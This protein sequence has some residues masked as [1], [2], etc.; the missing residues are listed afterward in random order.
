MA[1]LTDLATKRIKDLASQDTL[2]GFFPIDS[3]AFGTKKFDASKL[4]TKLMVETG[5]NSLDTALATEIAK[6]TALGMAVAD[7][8][9]KVKA[10][11]HFEGSKSVS[12]IS[13]MDVTSID[14]GTMYSCTDAGNIRYYSSS[15]G[16]ITTLKVRKF[17]EVAW[18]GTDWYIVGQDRDTD[19]S[20]YTKTA[21]LAPLAISGDWSDIANKP[22][23]A[24]VATSGSYRDLSDTPNGV[25]TISMNGTALATFSAGS[26]SNMTA[27]ITVPDFSDKED[28]SNKVNSIAAVASAS[29]KNYPSEK[30]VAIALS[31][32]QDTINNLNEIIAGATAGSTAAQPDDLADVAFSGDYNDLINTPSG[33]AEGTWHGNSEAVGSGNVVTDIDIDE[34]GVPQKTYGTAI[35]GI[36]VTDEEGHEE[37]APVDENGNVTLGGRFV[38]KNKIIEFSEEVE[39]VVETV[40]DLKQDIDTQLVTNF[41][42]ANITK[43]SDYG[44]LIGSKVDA[45]DGATAY[46]AFTLPINSNIRIIDPESDDT[47]T[48]L[49]VYATQSYSEPMMFGIFEYDYGT[50]Q[51]EYVADTGKVNITSGGRFDFPLKHKNPDIDQLSSGKLYYIAIHLRPGRGTGGPYLMSNDGINSTDATAINLNPQLMCWTKD[52]RNNPVIDFTQ[53]DVGF[54]VQ[55]PNGNYVYG[56]WYDGGYTHQFYQ[57]PAFF[58]QLR[59]SDPTPH[60]V[61]PSNPPFVDLSGETITFASATPSAVFNTADVKLILR[62][63]NP[64][65]NVTITEWTVYDNEQTDAAGYGKRIYNSGFTALTDENTSGITLTELGE[66]GSGTDIYGHKYTYAAGVQLT[67]NE[68]YYF[69]NGAPGSWQNISNFVQYDTPNNTG[70]LYGSSNPGYV[71]TSTMARAENVK[72]TYLKVKDSN[73]V[74]YVI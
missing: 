14:S 23:F 15:A 44:S 37:Q 26:F 33:P 4:A 7:L 74:E 45:Q 59:N 48:V 47:P 30:A 27:D 63:V 5:L 67:A 16:A 66:I 71:H 31:G 29:D 1:E 12:D 22:N 65:N 6:R 52:D 51:T 46:F 61:P 58:I 50:E 13:G 38:I 55:D 54:N 70:I 42:I 35:S 24:T 9:L 19:L 32:K 41:P 36:I 3:G 72:L 57:C 73:S 21:D 17:D 56:P 40:E 69:C 68:R 34:N 39:D 43:I 11:L 49:S 18:N 10:A 25:L 2:T 60:P 64:L 28:I 8:Q 20:E 53:D 62:A